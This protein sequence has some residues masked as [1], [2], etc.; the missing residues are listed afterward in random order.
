MGDRADPMGACGIEKDG[1]REAGGQ[2]CFEDFKG[3]VFHK[4]SGK[5]DLERIF[6]VAKGK[7]FEGFEKQILKK[8]V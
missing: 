1:L 3:E 5:N 6:K 8:G 2:S 4:S 7:G